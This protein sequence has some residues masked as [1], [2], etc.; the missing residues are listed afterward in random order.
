MTCAT[1]RQTS[2]RGYELLRDALRRL[3]GTEIETS[4]RQGGKNI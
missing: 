1:N 3:K 4:I 2:G